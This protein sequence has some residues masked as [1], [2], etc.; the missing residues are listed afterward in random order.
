MRLS[1]SADT[2]A[3]CGNYSAG[4]LTIFENLFCPAGSLPQF[5]NYVAAM[6]PICC[7]N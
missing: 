3:L 4:N 2:S 5:I 1:F 6:V 7:Q